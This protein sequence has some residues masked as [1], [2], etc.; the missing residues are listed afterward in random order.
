MASRSDPM[1]HSVPG[2]LKIAPA[3]YEH[4]RFGLVWRVAS[5]RWAYRPRGSYVTLDGPPSMQLA[6]ARCERAS[7]RRLVLRHKCE[8]SSH[9][10]AET[11]TAIATAS[12][13]RPP[14]VITDEDCGGPE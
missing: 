14:L 6:M 3:K 2:W 11:R 9:A 12:K 5:R 7:H 8:G 10:P 13:Q 4:P 1:S